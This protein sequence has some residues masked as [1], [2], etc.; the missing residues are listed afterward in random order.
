[1]VVGLIIAAC[2]LAQLIEDRL[3][4]PA[5]QRQV[6]LRLAILDRVLREHPRAGGRFKDPKVLLA[7]LDD[8]G[9]ETVLDR[10]TRADLLDL[11][12]LARPSTGKRDAADVPFEF[13]E[14]LIRIS[15]HVHD[16]YVIERSTLFRQIRDARN[17]RLSRRSDGLLKG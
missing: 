7:R 6:M 8:L 12:R 5:R 11:R 17:R 15:K 10:R 3:E 2:G 1:V 4:A 16:Q 14:R 9:I 13:E